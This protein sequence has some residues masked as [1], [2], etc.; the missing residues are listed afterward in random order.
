MYGHICP[1]CKAHLDP[2]EKCDC[3]GRHQTMRKMTHCDICDKELYYEDD[4]HEQDEAYEI[5][6][7]TVCE[8]CLSGYMRQNYY[9]R[10][11]VS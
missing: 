5:D 9:K 2:C 8:D 7:Y 4:L 10:L 1:I 11:R 6:G 3:D